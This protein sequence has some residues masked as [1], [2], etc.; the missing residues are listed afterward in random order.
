M[1]DRPRTR[2]P[3]G[4]LGAVDI[5]WTADYRLDEKSFTRLIRRLIGLGFDRLY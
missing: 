2:A 3:Q 5:P 1:P 4:M